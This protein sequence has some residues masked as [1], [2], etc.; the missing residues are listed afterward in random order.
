MPIEKVATMKQ[1]L[2]TH[3]AGMK[4]RENNQDVGK[5]VSS[6]QPCTNWLQQLPSSRHEI[7]RLM[8]EHPLTYIIIC[9]C[10]SECGG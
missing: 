3:C 8:T 4:R 6:E 10:T 9:A 2:T 5:S 1:I 7:A